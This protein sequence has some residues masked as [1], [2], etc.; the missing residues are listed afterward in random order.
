M[1]YEELHKQLTTLL[2]EGFELIPSPVSPTFSLKIDDKYFCFQKPL[3]M[4]LWAVRNPAD[5]EEQKD[6]E[7]KE[8]QELLADLRED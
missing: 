7:A 6:R 5:W 4:I 2:P 8:L 1:T 3:E